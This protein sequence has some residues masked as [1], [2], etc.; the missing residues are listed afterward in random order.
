[1]KS[2]IKVI[3]C[4]EL[5]LLAVGCRS[6]KLSVAQSDSTAHVN[7][8]ISDST[9]MRL[10]SRFRSVDSMNIDFIRWEFVDND[11]DESRLSAMT[12]GRVGKT[13]HKETM[14]DV[15]MVSNKMLEEKK[16]THV[17]TLQRNEPG[18]MRGRSRYIPMIL[19]LLIIFLVGLKSRK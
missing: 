3:I 4:V 19:A 5:S 17:A 12:I 7:T 8:T 6:H 14:K 15:K 1:M 11:S 16:D 18:V 10:W 2:T 13:R 9:D